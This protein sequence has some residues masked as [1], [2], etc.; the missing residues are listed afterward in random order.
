L[1]FQKELPSVH[2]GFFNGILLHPRSL[3]LGMAE[4]INS[5]LWPV[6]GV[7]ERFSISIGWTSGLGSWMV[8]QLGDF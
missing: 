4:R 5:G 7:I 8:I 6:C 3:C 1:I 2:L